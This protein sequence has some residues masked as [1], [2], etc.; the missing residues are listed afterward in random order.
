MDRRGCVIVVPHYDDE[1]L[2]AGSFL[3]GYAGPLLLVFT[4]QGDVLTCDEN[5]DEYGMYMEADE[6]IGAYRKEKGFGPVHSVS[7]IQNGDRLSV[8]HIVEAA[9]RSFEQVDY[10]VS[11]LRT[12][13]Q[14]HTESSE[15]CMSALRNDMLLRTRCVLQAPYPALTFGCTSHSIDDTYYTSFMP[16]E[17]TAFGILHD[18]IRVDYKEKCWM[19]ATADADA[20][21]LSCEFYGRKAGFKYAMPFSSRKIILGEQ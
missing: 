9:L 7:D 14:S 6:R 19:G 11:S 2:Q 20:F 15:I 4:H 12:G 18:C 21:K 8:L 17:E 5:N 3:V 16:M 10:F 13:H 1:I